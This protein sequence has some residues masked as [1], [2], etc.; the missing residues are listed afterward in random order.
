MSY[1]L[2]VTCGKHNLLR[3]SCYHTYC[4][5][6]Y[7]YYIYCVCLYPLTLF[8]NPSQWIALREF[9]QDIPVYFNGKSHGFRFQFSLEN[10]AIDSHN[11]GLPRPGETPLIEPR[12]SF[13]RGSDSGDFDVRRQGEQWTVPMCD[14]GGFHKLGGPSNRWFLLGKIPI[15]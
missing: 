15:K 9:F 2:V 8:I 1:V 10:Q 14:V 4:I 3:I 7:C 5:A 6:M 12:S 11:P 13:Q